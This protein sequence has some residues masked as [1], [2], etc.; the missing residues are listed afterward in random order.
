MYWPVLVDSTISQ[1]L[2]IQECRQNVIVPCVSYQWLPHSLLL[3]THRCARPNVCAA[4]PVAYDHTSTRVHIRATKQT[5]AH[6]VKAAAIRP[7]Q[8]PPTHIFNMFAT[9]AQAAVPSTSTMPTLESH[10]SRGMDAHSSRKY[11][12][13]AV[14]ST[15]VLF[16]MLRHSSKSSA[17]ELERGNQML[18]VWW[19]ML[20]ADESAVRSVRCWSLL[21]VEVLH[22]CIGGDTLLVCVSLCWAPTCVKVTT[23]IYGCG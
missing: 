7:A 8:L 9:N 14:P 4:F 16:G 15:P 2:P 22:E 12:T 20:V 19:Y 18:F 11:R 10:T 21:G 1:H 5:T 17:V 6:A 23:C 13:V 3:I